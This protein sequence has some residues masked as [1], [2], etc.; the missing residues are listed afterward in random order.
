MDMKIKKWKEEK[1]I[2]FIN[3]NLIITLSSFDKS[4]GKHKTI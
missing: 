1:I 4:W 3:I 2:K